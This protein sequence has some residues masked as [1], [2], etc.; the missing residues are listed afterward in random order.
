MVEIPYFW[1]KNNSAAV[2]Q[3]FG[4]LERFEFRSKRFESIL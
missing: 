1:V 4:T 3:I 2:A